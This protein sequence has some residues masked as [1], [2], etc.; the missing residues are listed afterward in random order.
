MASFSP[1]VGNLA[2]RHAAA[3]PAPRPGQLSSTRPSFTEPS[4]AVVAPGADDLSGRNRKAAID[5]HFSQVRNFSPPL[6]APDFVKI[7]DRQGGVFV[8]FFPVTGSTG[9]EVTVSSDENFNT[10]L[11]RE[12]WEGERNTENFVGVGNLNQDIFARVR[13]IGGNRFSTTIARGECGTQLPSGSSTTID[14]ASPELPPAP[15]NPDLGVDSDPLTPNEEL[16]P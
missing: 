6:S 10:V 8:Q 12:R 13:T 3:T 7:T 14:T 5:Q 11:R 15:I 4:Y 9:Y 2:Q 1:P 16:L